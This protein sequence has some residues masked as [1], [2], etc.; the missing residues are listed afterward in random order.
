M[1]D[2]IACW[3]PTVALLPLSPES[4]RHRPELADRMSIRHT[5]K[6]TITIKDARIGQMTLSP[7]PQLGLYCDQ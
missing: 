6:H 5:L 7:F 2:V 3:W 4:E 1:F